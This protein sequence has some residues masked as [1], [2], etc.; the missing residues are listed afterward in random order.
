LGDLNV[1]YSHSNDISDSTF[2]SLF[3]IMFVVFTLVITIVAF[4]IFMSVVIDAYSK[5]QEYI[6][7]R[8]KTRDDIDVPKLDDCK[9]Y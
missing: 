7:E 8:E 4:N 3:V 9:S 5:A 6:E 2:R 1:L